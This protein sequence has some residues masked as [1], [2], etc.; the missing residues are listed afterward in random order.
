MT[1]HVQL[2]LPRDTATW[3]TAQ[4]RGIGFTDE[5][6]WLFHEVR[7]SPLRPR[8]VALSAAATVTTTPSSVSDELPTEP[9]PVHLVILLAAPLPVMLPTAPLAGA[10]FAPSHA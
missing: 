2:K 9:T 5:A 7:K 3:P 1:E 10:Q 4:L 6:S 8:L